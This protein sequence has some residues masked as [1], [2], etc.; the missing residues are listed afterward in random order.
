MCESGSWDRDCHWFFILSR[1]I[2]NFPGLGYEK[3]FHTIF[4][5][6]IKDFCAISEP[7]NDTDLTRLLLPDDSTGIKPVMRSYAEILVN[8][9][10]PRSNPMCQTVWRYVERLLVLI[11][12]PVDLKNQPNYLSFYMKFVR[13]FIKCFLKRVRKE[14]RKDKGIVENEDYILNHED[15]KLWFSDIRPDESIS[16]EDNSISSNSNSASHL[17]DEYCISEFTRLMKSLFP[18]VVMTEDSSN[19]EVARICLELSTFDSSFLELSLQSI[20]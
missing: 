4:Q 15:M 6:L 9:L 19:C 5:T 2:E 8:L 17:L 10:V 12:R 11:I 1:L 14:R 16:T 18:T 3:Y 20:T 7:V 13:Q